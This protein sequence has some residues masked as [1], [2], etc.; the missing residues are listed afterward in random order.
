M[1]G[2]K[3]KSIRREPPRCSGVLLHVSSLPS[4]FG[5][6]DL[7]PEA[8]RFLDFLDRAGQRCWQVLPL[9]P[10]D[11]LFGNSPYNS[12]SA[13]AGNLLFI[14]PEKMAEDGLLAAR[15]L[16]RAPTFRQGTID[17]PA[18]RAFKQK[19]FHRAFERFRTRRETYEDAFRQFRS[20]NELWLRDYA[21]FAALKCRYRGSAW[22]GWPADIRRRQ[23]DAVRIAEEDLRDAVE[24]EEFLQFVFYRQ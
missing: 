1:G 10:V 5:I 7:G 14:S 6:G 11:P 22:T 8:F 4:R 12:S 16:K 17:Y 13:F 2:T 23:P 9:G 21:L 24:W 18:V 20:A 3:Q 15:D 19:L